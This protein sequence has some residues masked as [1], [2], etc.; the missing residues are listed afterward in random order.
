M[1]SIDVS[2][3]VNVYGTNANDLIIAGNHSSILYGA[4]GFNELHGSTFNDILIAGNKTDLM[5]GGA[6]SDIFEVALD[7]HHE[8]TSRDQMD[9]T[10][11]NFLNLNTAQAH[12]LS[13][14]IQAIHQSS[15]DAIWSTDNSKAYHLNA[16][17]GDYA[18]ASGNADRLAFTHGS[19][20]TEIATYTIKGET[21]GGHTDLIYSFAKDFADTDSGH[22][23]SDITAVLMI[24]DSG[25]DIQLLDLHNNGISKT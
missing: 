7:L 22:A 9:V 6:G 21:W 17:V 8:T 18:R 3:A 19:D 24:P 1:E 11:A 4:D 5:Y 13:D 12:A 2:K 10:L 25:L 15:G 14:Q 23:M 16:V 20:A